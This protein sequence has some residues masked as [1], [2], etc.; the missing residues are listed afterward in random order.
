VGR[1]IAR[2]VGIF[3]VLAALAAPAAHA[4]IPSGS[5]DPSWD[6]DGLNVTTVGA[7]VSY[8]YAAVL[9]PDLKTVVAGRS[10]NL[11]DQ[12]QFAVVRYT[13][14]GALDPAW[15]GDG[16]Q[17]TPIP[18]ATD[19]KAFAMVIQPDGKLVVAG[20]AA[21]AG[22]NEWQWGVVRY[23]TNGTPDPTFGG[24]DG[25]VRFPMG[26]GNCQ[27][28]GYWGN[29]A[30]GVAL[31]GSKIVVAGCARQGA[32]DF[33]ALA[34]LNSDGSLD[35]N[36]PG[37][38]N[39]AD[40]PFDTDGRQFHDVA[41]ADNKGAYPM[42]VLVD[43]SGE[44]AV[45]GWVEASSDIPVLVR[46]TPD[47]APIGAPTT[48]PFGQG[49]RIVAL[50][51]QSDGKIVAGG[52]SALNFFAVRF[53]AAGALDPTFNGGNPNSTAIPPGTSSWGGGVAV[54]PDGKVVVGGHVTNGTNN[55]LGLV[56][57]TSSGA[58]DPTFGN[59]G[60]AFLP[61]G[62]DQQRNGADQTGV[63]VPGDGKIII[64]GAGGQ[65]DQGGGHFAAARVFAETILTDKDQDQV[66]DRNDNCIDAPN[67]DQTDTDGDGAGDACDTD[68]DNDQ[69]GDGTDNCP[70]RHNPGQADRDGDGMGDECDADD[71]G[72]G[73]PDDRDNC[74]T[75]ANPSQR[76]DDR[77]GVGDVCD[78]TPPGNL[79]VTINKGDSFTNNANVKLT[80]RVPDGTTSLLIAN[81]GGFVGGQTFPVRADATY[82]WVLNTERKDVT[83]IVYVR[84]VGPDLP[85]YE[86][87]DDIVLDSVK[88]VLNFAKRGKGGRSLAISARDPKPASGVALM[89]VTTNKKRPG[90][91]RKFA[92]SIR[93]NKNKGPFFVRVRDKAGNFSGWKR[94]RRGNR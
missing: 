44:I 35:D 49:A 14:N 29:A 23:N 20:R 37:D 94:E 11:A 92:R 21:N 62:A 16:R 77:D 55:G 67:T 48:V 34:R 38:Q 66:L 58:E 6:T 59:S 25:I 32:R 30:Y 42:D 31:Q 41:G 51:R 91:L 57:Y 56:R 10:R 53:T 1:G 75:V 73:V 54:G 15:N 43:G 74:P 71:D 9:Q 36:N 78:P 22:A 83:K 52:T 39:L 46:Y 89:Q 33:F 76:D 27:N 24:G 18:G 70:L 26:N 2:I 69:R 28:A 40:T 84:A 5:F 12:D 60:T 65:G 13:R 61:T 79:S 50:D 8:G 90:K 81:D 3:G 64:A 85:A 88:P 47:G 82:D 45:G 86:K 63:L 7:G 72:D 19:S 68:D 87:S 93:V 4:D 80:V 17:Q